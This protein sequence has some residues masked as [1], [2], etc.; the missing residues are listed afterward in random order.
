MAWDRPI[1]TDSGGFQ[2][3]SLSQGERGDKKPLA[4]ID[5][6]GVTFRSHLDG[7]KHRMD[8]EESMRVQMALGADIIMA[9]DECP[10][11]GAPRDVVVRAMQRTT[12]W[13]ERSARA[14]TRPESRLF[15][16]IQGGIHDDLRTE[17]AQQLTSTFDLFGWAIGGL[18]VGESKDDMMRAL[19]TTTHHMPIHKPRY[20]MGV[21]TPE[22]LLDGIAR[23]VDMFD[24]V[25]PTRNARNATLF[26]SRGKMSIKT[27]QYVEDTR[28]IDE[29]CLCYTC[30]TFTRA[31]MR[32]LW[33]ARE[34]LFYRL[35]SLHNVSFYLDVMARAR[36][37]IE[38]KRFAAF[39]ADEK[40]RWAAGPG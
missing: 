27:A 25:M 22:D 1:L 6:D 4:T 18:S 29:R 39:A 31:Y 3:F 32:H 19:A 8:A 24:C 16:I 38:E 17:H 11:G 33:N 12:K 10:P 21:G 36:V 2:V 34:L 13:L 26:T 40:A 9:F 15:G 14:M 28:P 20:L 30:R 37:A 23:G 5:D 35:A 7:K